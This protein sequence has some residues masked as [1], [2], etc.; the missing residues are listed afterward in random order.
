MGAFAGAF[1]SLVYLILAVVEITALF[2]L[3]ELSHTRSH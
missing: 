1:A 3:G 2:K